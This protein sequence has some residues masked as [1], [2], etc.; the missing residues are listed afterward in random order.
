MFLKKITIENFRSI[1]DPVF[2]DI[3]KIGHKSCYILLGINE[4]GKSVILDAISIIDKNKEVNYDL[5]CNIDL[6]G[7]DILLIF[8]LMIIDSDFYKKQFIEKGL[9]KSLVQGIKIEKIERK[10]NID[11]NNDR[12]DY[13]HIYI[14]DNKKKFEQYIIN[15]DKIEL[16]TK[17]NTVENEEDNSTNILDKGKLETY[18]ENTFFDIFDH[19]TPKMIFWKYESK[20][21]INKEIDLNEFKN[22]YDISIPL[23]N[24]FKIADVENIKEKIEFVTGSPRKTESLQRKLGDVITSYINKVWPEHKIDV[25]IRIDNMKLSF[26]VNDKDNLI[27]QYEVD[28]RSDGFRHF[29]SIM[30][31]LSIENKIADLKNKIILI[32]EPE[33]HLHPSGEKYLQNELLNIAKNNVV[34]FATHSIFMVDKSNLDRHFS[35]KK[36]KGIT[37]VSQIEKDNPYKEEVLYE[38]L[39]TSILEHISNKVLLLEGKIDRDIFDL[40]TKKFKRDLSPVNISTISTDGCQNIIKYTKFFNTKLIKGFVLVDSDDTGKTEKIKILDLSNYNKKNVFEINDILNT[41]KDSEVEDLFDKT[42]LRK[43]FKE[44]CDL[45]FSFDDNI[46][47]MKQLKDKMRKEKKRFK[48]TEKEMLKKLFFKQIIKLKKED[49]KKQ[50]YFKF[51]KNLQDKLKK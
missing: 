11:K 49:L 2:F 7:E 35:V 21:L 24:I 40:Y 5:D 45:E 44:F 19:N 10:V 22:N 17:E 20:Y 34:F 31:N 25:R 43:A 16:K 3:K 4:S 41:E 6:Y 1:K 38:A 28:Q 42:F 8:E 12:N 36:D 26:L 33:I 18:L 13:F 9:E 27:P 47:F 23:K 48:D 37:T 50:K 15:D 29:V 32:D 39:G 51:Y 30:L 46:P 14:K